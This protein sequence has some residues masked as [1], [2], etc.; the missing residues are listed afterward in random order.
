MRRY[1]W[2]GGGSI[3]SGYLFGI[4][5]SDDGCSNGNVAPIGVFVGMSDSR[6]RHA[7]GGTGRG[8]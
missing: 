1:S 2:H 4:Y 5:A 3:D 7:P 8:T 6:K